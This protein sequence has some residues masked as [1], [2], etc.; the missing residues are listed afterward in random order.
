[1]SEALS[2]DSVR[3]S[4]PIEVP[5]RN[6]PQI[7]QIFD[8]ISYY[9][10]SSIIRMLSANLSDEVFLRGVSDYLRQH[11]YRTATASAL[12]S[13]VSKASGQDVNQIMD[14]WIKSIGLPILTVVEE[15]GQPAHRTQPACLF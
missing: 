15:S 8:A 4:H 6:A 11:A 2:L 12:W 5:V 7:A 3:Q 14:S 1:M 13:A 9:K 10:G